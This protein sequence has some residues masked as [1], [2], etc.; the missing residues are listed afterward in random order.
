[1]PQRKAQTAYTDKI[2]GDAVCELE[3]S[4]VLPNPLWA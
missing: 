4:V 1:M 3:S 2:V